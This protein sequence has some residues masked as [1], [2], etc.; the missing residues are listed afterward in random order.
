MR[1]PMSWLREYAQTSAST[2][3]IAERLTVSSL[4]VERV[5][6]CGRRR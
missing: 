1:V 5:I 4:E 3:A 2:V 6:G